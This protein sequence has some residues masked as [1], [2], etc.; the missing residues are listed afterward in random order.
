MNNFIFIGGIGTGKSTASKIFCDELK[1]RGFTPALISYDE[2]VAAFY[3]KLKFYSDPRDQSDLAFQEVANKVM[4]VFLTFD[5]AKISKIAFADPVKLDL[6]IKIVSPIISL[7][8]AKAVSISKIECD[9]IVIE[10]PMYLSCMEDPVLE[11]L[12]KYQI[13]GLTAPLSTKY[14]RLLARGL[15][16]AE[17]DQIIEK[18]PSDE[19]VAEASTQL[20]DNNQDVATL[21]RR[22]SV[23]ADKC[24]TTKIGI[25]S[26]SFDPI[27]RGHLWVISKG[28]NLVDKLHVVIAAN[29][30]KVSLFSQLEK[31]SLIKKSIVEVFDKDVI[32]KIVIEFA[33][34]DELLVSLAKR[35]K[36][37]YIF[38][39]IRNFTDFE[40]EKQINTIQHK[41]DD[42]IETIFL[43]PPVEL[44]EVS[45]STVK[46]LMKFPEWKLI[47]AQ[48]ITK[49]VQ[50]GL[51]FKNSSRV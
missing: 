14:R 50:S 25:V 38:R 41:V 28:A 27:T 29:P 4:G 8:L 10:F 49:A 51:N 47:S 40:Y 19:A 35:R 48:Y 32:E 16:L 44:T 45:S 43:M 46:S 7:E 17:A 39:G 15:T 34:T 6:L 5:K 26:G 31:S 13:V 12:K 30:S 22:L 33:E 11:F 23:I 3:K 18:Q 21:T 37:K 9:A 2:L 20:I 42:S 1:Q 36:A 24:P